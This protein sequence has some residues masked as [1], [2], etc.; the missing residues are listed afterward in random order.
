MRLALLSARLLLA[1]VFAVAGLAK[2]ADRAGSRQTLSDF[3]MPALFVSPLGVLLPLAELTIAVALV[4]TIAAWW[5]SLGALALLLLFV[6]AIGYNLARGQQPD[7]HSFGQLRL[8]PAGWPTLIRNLVLA[9]LAGFVV[10]FGRIDTGPSV[11]VWLGALALA[12][13]IELLVG[14]LVV[15]L[16]VLEGWV[17]LQVMGQQGRLLLRLEAVEARLSTGGTAMQ[18]TRTGDTTLPSLGLPVGAPAPAFGLPNLNGETITLDALRAPGKPV[19]LIFSDPSCGPCTALLP[20]IGCWQSDYGARLTLALLSSGTSEANSAK[21]SEHGISHVLLQQGREVGEVYRTPEMPNAVFVRPDGTIGSPPAQGAEAI[22]GLVAGVLGLPVLRP[23]PLAAP[24]NGN[25]PESSSSPNKHVDPT[26][27][28]RTITVGVAL[29]QGTYALLR[30]GRMDA[31]LITQMLLVH[32]LGV[33]EQMLDMQGELSPTQEREFLQLLKRCEDGEPVG[34]LVGHTKFYGRDFLVD[35]RVWIPRSHTERLAEAAMSAVR[36]MLHAGRTPLVAEIGTGSGAIAITLAVEEPRLPYLYATDLSA[37]AVE[38]AHL[39]CQRHGVEQ[40]IHLLHGDLVAP[41]PEP[42]D[43]IIAN[44]PYLGMDEL[45]MVTP[46][47]RAYEPHVAL[48]GG[49]DGLELLQ[50][51]FVETQQLRVLRDKAVLLFEVDFRQRET[52]I[53]RLHEI[54]PQATVTFSKDCFGVDRVLQAF[55]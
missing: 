50:R 26:V 2:L 17:I 15:A 20:E 27:E 54:W 41:L 35:P 3:G 45:D 48:F 28:A 42:V 12:Q 6:A 7:C 5:A 9:T 46:A 52:L 32:M 36:H 31:R 33:G 19:V 40:R 16:V 53:A 13:R 55:L 18:P 47:V 39:N 22:R 51:F 29:E 1:V 34:Y 14:V 11:L 43:I 44:L 25:R 30:K 10:G 21:A 38:V 49:P 37:D 8:A 23:K 24:I 4:P